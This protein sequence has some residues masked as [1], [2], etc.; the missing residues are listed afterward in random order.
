[1]DCAEELGA[2]GR[3]EKK[4]NTF[5]ELILEEKYFFGFVKKNSAQVKGRGGAGAKVGVAHTFHAGSNAVTKK[6]KA[7]A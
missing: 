2:N 1:M 5:P 7:S 6:T 3:P 4:W